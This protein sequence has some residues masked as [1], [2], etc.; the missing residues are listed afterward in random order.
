MLQYFLWPQTSFG[1]QAKL[2]QG[3]VVH[4]QEQLELHTGALC[5]WYVWL[6]PGGASVRAHARTPTRILI[7]WHLATFLPNIEAEVKVS[8]NN[9]PWSW[10]GNSPHKCYLVFIAPWPSHAGP[11]PGEVPYTV[12]STHLGIPIFLYARLWVR[13]SAQMLLQHCCSAKNESQRAR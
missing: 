2:K 11:S 4:R 9:I 13:M 5:P 10:P 8:L 12:H 1:Q 6:T 7:R 3:I